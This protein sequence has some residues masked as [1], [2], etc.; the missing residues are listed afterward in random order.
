MNKA[1][2]RRACSAENFH[3]ESPGHVP[4]SPG[5]LPVMSPACSSHVQS[6]L[7]MFRVFA[8]DPACLTELGLNIL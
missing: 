2:G 7:V 1:V 4:G 3:P 8:L 6:R 5:H